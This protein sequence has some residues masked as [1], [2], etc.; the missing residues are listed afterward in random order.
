MHLP[1]TLVNRE[2]VSCFSRACLAQRSSPSRDRPS[3]SLELCPM[4]LTTAPNVNAA[5]VPQI[6]PIKVPSAT[7]PLH[8][9]TPKLTTTDT[10][11]NTTVD[12][13]TVPASL[14]R[15]LH[16]SSAFASVMLPTLFAAERSLT[17]NRSAAM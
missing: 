15:I 3:S 8:H 12:N 17:D 10:T 4:A 16:P 6:T 11:K 2:E 1:R 9:K 13:I 14:A 5:A 7:S